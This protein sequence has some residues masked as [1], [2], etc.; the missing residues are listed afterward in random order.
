MRKPH[1]SAALLL[2][3]LAALCAP[4]LAIE[5]PALKYVTAKTPREVALEQ[6]HA[7]ASS[8][9]E[10]LRAAARAGGQEREDF[11][12]ELAG[13]TPAEQTSGAEPCAVRISAK[14]KVDYGWGIGTPTAV[15][16]E[17]SVRVTKGRDVQVFAMQDAARIGLATVPGSIDAAHLYG[18]RFNEPKVAPPRFQERLLV[19]LDASG[20]ASKV[21]VRNLYLGAGGSV[22][23][24]SCELGAR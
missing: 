13:M 22:S 3:A 1:R 15:V 21:T 19:A 2:T 16:S 11:T 24:L 7:K 14:Y 20:A 9:A 18:A 23:S 10:A 5:E 6:A 12:A 17:L 4:A 8:L